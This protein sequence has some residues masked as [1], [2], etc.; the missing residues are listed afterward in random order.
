MN[1]HWKR[2]KTNVV[3]Y[4]WAFFVFA[5]CTV[6]VNSKV[7]PLKT[8]VDTK[9][10]DGGFNYQKYFNLNPELFADGKVPSFNG[11]LLL[12]PCRTL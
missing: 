5:R 11:N 6:H 4:F 12:R 1:S 7:H 9:L 3:F 8:K 10:K 2:R